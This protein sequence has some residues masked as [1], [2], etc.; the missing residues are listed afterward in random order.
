MTFARSLCL[1]A[2]LLASSA[3]LMP[4]LSSAASA[5]EIAIGLAGP[6]SGPQ[7]YFGTTWH[8]GFKL[9]WDKLN[10]A[11]GVN[12]T[13]VAYEQED[14]KADPREGTLV[15]Q[16]FCDDDNV[17]IGL[18]NFNS[19]VA[20]STLPIYEECSLP[21]MTFGS[22]PSLTHQ[23]YKMM[24]R[25]VA[26][27]LAGALLPAEYALK[28]LGAKTAIVVSDKQVFG[29]GI[30]E[31]FSKNFTDGGG[32]VVD[33]LAVAPTDVDFTAVLAQIKTKSP[34][35]IY[36]GAVMPQLALF[37][38]QM[39]EQGIKAT[40]LVPDGGY[41]PDYIT[42]AGEANVQGS[43]V[44]IQVPPMDASPDI[45]EFAKLYKEKYGE[46][47]GPY[48]IY[49]YVQGQILEEV[50]KTTKGLT[51]EDI[52]TA[53]H[54][55]KVK[56]AVGELEFDEIGELKVAPSYLYKVEGTKFVLAGQK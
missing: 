10:A 28:T 5:E 38:K 19:G 14:D 24:V 42:Q 4:V 2:S 25:P 36:L 31:I 7:A 16:K 23:G 17:L 48:S 53:L 51:R 6:L 50:L 34:E 13:T 15:A 54:N 49:G 18:V 26:N 22:N 56:T 12:G 35:V 32:K 8:N 39:H 52:N 43:L 46:E 37:A 47:A 29:Q 41:T 40:L 21:T 45:A 33:T 3:L 1:G 55:V 9:Y 27:D 11:G 20:Q 30:S 44:A